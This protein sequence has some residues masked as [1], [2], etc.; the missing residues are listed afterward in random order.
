M[1]VGVAGLLEV[2]AFAA[3]GAAGGVTGAVAV[4]W[5]C[6][7]VMAPRTSANDIDANNHS[8]AR[9]KFDS[10]RFDF[11]TG[12]EFIST[13]RQR[14]LLHVPFGFEELHKAGV[15]IG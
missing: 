11:F 8:A 3:G 10:G 6:A 15:G 4:P 14:L 1:T 13:N 5:A 7:A 12:D 9:G 2:A